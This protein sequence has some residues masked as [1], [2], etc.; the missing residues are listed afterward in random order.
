MTQSRVIGPVLLAACLSCSGPA[1]RPPQIPT[2]EQLR[3][4]ALAM[5]RKEGKQVLLLFTDPASDFPDTNWC[6]LFDKYHADADVSRVINTHLVLIR[7]DITETPG[8]KQ[9]YF[10]F[11]GVGSVP[12][13]SILDA[14]G[15]LLANSGD[16]D[17]NIGFPAQP[18]EVDHYFAALKVA[19]P[20]LSDDEIDVLRKKLTDL[21]PKEEQ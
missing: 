20:K 12:S 5:A 15:M 7:I 14:H 3:A 17:Q 18:H 1:S 19:C 8:G 9:M 6:E 16:G 2:A 4:D 11:G 13:F 21:R 10:E